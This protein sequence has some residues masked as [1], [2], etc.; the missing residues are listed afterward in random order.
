VTG[1]SVSVGRIVLVPVNPATNN[2]QDFAPAVVTKAWDAV[3]CNVRVLLD[4]PG[5]DDH[6][7]SLTYVEE[8]P[9]W[10]P[11]NGNMR[12]WSWPPRV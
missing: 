10:D 12:V 6:R 5:Q 1:Q 11:D 8:V 3:V 9:A 2:G 7:T 4:L